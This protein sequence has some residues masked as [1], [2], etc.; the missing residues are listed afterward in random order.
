MSER[1]GIRR[2]TG[3]A[4][5]DL[6]ADTITRVLQE[7][8]PPGGDFVVI[9]ATPDRAQAIENNLSAQLFGYGPVRDEAVHGP[10]GR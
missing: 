8:E 5:A 7:L 2:V 10:E 9:R 4:V 1:V 6:P 3:H